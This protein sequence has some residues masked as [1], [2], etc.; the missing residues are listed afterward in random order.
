MTLTLKS[1][2]F[3][4]QREPD[5]LALED[6]VT[7][8]KLGGIKK[9][10]ATEL[11]DLPR[12][13]RATLSS[14]SVAR[15]IALDRNLLL[16]LEDLSLR[17]YL[18]IYGPQRSWSATA[19]HFLTEGFPQAARQAWPHILAAFLCVLAG[20]IAG[21][22]LADRDEAWFSTFIPP[23]MAGGRGPGSTR[24]D[25]LQH[26]LFAPWPGASESFGLM[27]S[28]LFQHNTIVGI[29][30]FGLGI[31]AGI[32]TIGLLLYQGLVFGSFLC[33]HAHRGLLLDCIGWVSIHG[34]TEFG[35]IIISGAG[36]LFIAEKLVFPGRLTRAD[37]LALHGETASRLAVGAML[38]FL[39]A[40]ILEGGFRQLVANTSLRLLIGFAVG[41]CWIAEKRY[42]HDRHPGPH[43]GIPGRQH[44]PPP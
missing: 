27:A 20:S 1:A 30:S 32:P 33:L 10:S 16:Y 5:W 12:L 28:F 43:H 34:V 17:A 23:A 44:P 19:R 37:S 6:L 7:R 13:Y 3:R 21:Y 24:T 9:L 39:L 4:T 15:A 42:A 11:Q 40:A 26:E 2:T 31:F 18:V 14:L 25:L 35:A 29:L 8:V 22:M 41:A 38:L 36:G